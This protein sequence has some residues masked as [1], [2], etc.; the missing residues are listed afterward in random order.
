MSTIQKTIILNRRTIILEDKIVRQ[1]RACKNAPFYLTTFHDSC[2]LYYSEK[3]KE[4][5]NFS[6]EKFL[7]KFNSEDELIDHI[8]K[9]RKV[10]NKRK[11]KQYYEGNKRQILSRIKQAIESETEEEKE[12]RLKKNRER[13]LKYYNKAKEKINEKNKKWYEKNKEYVKRKNRRNY[14]KRKESKDEK[15]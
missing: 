4:A 6:P 9:V 12:E 2:T 14:L 1:Y 5:L 11:V 15:A 13:S 10:V 8:D 3:I 7:I